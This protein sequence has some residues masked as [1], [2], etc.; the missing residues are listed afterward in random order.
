MFKTNVTRDT[1]AIQDISL[2]LVDMTHGLKKIHSVMLAALRG[3]AE[4]LRVPK[5]SLLSFF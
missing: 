4:Y 2:L 1:R 5:I 3:K